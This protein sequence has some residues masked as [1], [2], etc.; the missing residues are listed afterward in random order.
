M[1]STNL[2]YKAGAARVCITPSEPLW[3]A[4]YAARTEPARGTI[5]D[6]YAS[7]VAIED[8]SG[9]RFVIASADL[10]AVTKMLADPIAEIVQR[11]T[12][13]PRQRLLLAATHTH[14]GPEYRPD[15]ALFFKIPPQWA[16]KFDAVAKRLVEA[17]ANVI[18]EALQRMEPARVIARQTSA[19]FAH[20]RRRTGVVGGEAST[21]D[22]FDHDVPVLDVLDATGKRKAVVFGYACHNTTLEPGDCRYCADWAGV[23]KRRIAAAHPGAVPLFIAGAG[24]DQNPDPRG[25]LELSQ[26]YGRELADAILDELADDSSGHE[27]TG[28]IRVAAEEVDLPL[29]PVTRE[30][31]DAMLASDDPPK[32]VKARFLLDQMD[33][34]EELITSYPAPVQV[35]RFGQELLLVALSGEPVVDWA[36]KFKNFLD[37]KARRIWVAGYCNDMYGYVPTR[38]IQREGGYEGGRANL[39]SWIPAPFNEELEDRI[40]AAVGRLVRAV[41]DE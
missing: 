14:Y 30:R 5:S 25:T 8:A 29:E 7:A 37:V 31:L 27:I 6:L 12:G 23:A 16:A 10:I 17:I 2:P 18:I 4:G 3:L 11:E 36:M 32:R 19:G 24:A 13:L 39:W 15:K 34:G 41:L 9:E 26:Q 33:R 40:S 21:E 28:P 1:V 35:A 20:N 22:I 38:R